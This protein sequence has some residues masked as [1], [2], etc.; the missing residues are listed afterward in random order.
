MNLSRWRVFFHR[1][2]STEAR[3]L[4]RESLTTDSDDLPIG[5]FQSE[6]ILAALVFEDLEFFFHRILLKLFFRD[7]LI[8]QK[9]IDVISHRCNWVSSQGFSNLAIDIQNLAEQGA[10]VVVVV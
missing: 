10:S 7:P 3:L 5:C 4:G 8:S 2:N 1:L 6:S 9:R